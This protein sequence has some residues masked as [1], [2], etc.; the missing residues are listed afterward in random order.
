MSYDSLPKGGVVL[1]LEFSIADAV[2]QRGLLAVLGAAISAWWH[3][4]RMPDN[5]P[6]RLR[7]DIGLP[8]DATRAYWLDIAPSR[9]TPPPLRRPGM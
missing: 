9:T 8:P 6:D 5:L 7:A 4:P 1:R 3:R 2:Y